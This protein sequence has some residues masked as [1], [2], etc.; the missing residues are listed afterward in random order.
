MMDSEAALAGETPKK[1]SLAAGNSSDESSVQRQPAGSPGEGEPVFLVIGKLRRPHGI[2]GE[3]LMDVLTD[4]PERLEKGVIIYLGDQHRPLKIRSC[5]WQNK[6]MLLTFDGFMDP[7]TAGQ[8]RNELLYVRADDRP[9]LPEGE[10][11]HHQLLGLEVV[12]ENGKPLGVL[13]KIL[14]TGAN[15]VYVVQPARGQEILLPAI[16]QVI[17]DI[18]LER[19]QMRV[20]ILPGLIP[21]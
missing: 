8:L 1:E 16:E 12:D 7:E 4:F 9:P 19:K 14:D 5:R 6:A 21:D 20:H 11:Y 10:Y 18:D 3:I 13:T 17:L 2:Q 15:D